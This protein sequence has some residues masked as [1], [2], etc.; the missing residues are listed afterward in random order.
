MQPKVYVNFQGLPKGGAFGGVRLRL[1]DGPTHFY[2]DRLAWGPLAVSARATDAGMTAYHLGV[3]STQSTSLGSFYGRL[4]GY[5]VSDSNTVLT[6][7][8]RFTPAWR[9]LGQGIKAYVSTDTRDVKFNSLNYW[10]P[11]SG[12]GT[13]SVG[14]S[15]EWSDKDWV[16][17]SSGQMGRPIYGESGNSWSASAGGKRW[18]G[19][20]YALGLNMWGM[21]SWRDGANYRA[22]SM[23]VNLE[24]LW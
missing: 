17:Y 2:A 23:T 24:K 19:K 8:L 4:S 21:S 10:S 18:L 7:A 15:A 9:P 5:R 16:L 22:R 11:A 13:V 6:S 12:S 1:A 3:E 20:D 14:L